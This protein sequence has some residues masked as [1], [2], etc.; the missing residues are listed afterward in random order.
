MTTI[1][2]LAE[3]TDQAAFERLATAILREAEPQ[4]AALI[5]PGVNKEGKTVKSP[6]DGIG[7]VR[8]AHPAHL[9]VVH[10]TTCKRDGLEKKWL[11]IPPR[12]NAR[13]GGRPTAPAGDFIKSLE[14]IRK[15]RATDP[16]LEATLVLTTNQEPPEDLV[17]QVHGFGKAQD[18]PRLTSIPDLS[19]L[20]SIDCTRRDWSI[21]WRAR[22]I[23]AFAPFL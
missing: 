4:Y 9:I 10:H 3:M 7:F 14:V 22:A 11:H 17:R 23:A 20:P 8:G 13:R 19:A 21:A 2:K 18:A 15:E 6:V 12:A 5:H 1:G 16:S